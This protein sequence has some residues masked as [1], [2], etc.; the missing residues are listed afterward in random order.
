MLHTCILKLLK[1]LKS[2]Y[3]GQITRLAR[4][5]QAV[6]NRETYHQLE[7]D[8]RTLRRAITS[9][10]TSRAQ[11]SLKE[12]SQ[13][14]GSTLPIIPK[15]S[16]IRNLERWNQTL[17]QHGGKNSNDLRLTSPRVSLGL[18]EASIRSP[19][20]SRPD[21]S[22]SASYEA[23]SQELART[24]MRERHI[25]HQ[26]RMLSGENSLLPGRDRGLAP[27]NL[28]LGRRPFTRRV[29]FASTP[30]ISPRA[31]TG[32]VTGENAHNFRM[33]TI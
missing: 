26:L 5:Q 29:N 1:Y 14:A 12:V 18:Q 4:N 31:L 23:L 32:S 13:G 21:G 24:R 20:I 8:L 30:Q 17:E 3:L 6:E 10:M 22:A 7:N 33:Q 15:D 19:I 2:H 11:T 16:N 28:L 9:L 27:R 25:L